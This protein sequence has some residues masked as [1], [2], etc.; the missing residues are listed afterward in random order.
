MSEPPREQRPRARPTE[1]I[2]LGTLP[3]GP[4]DTALNAD[5]PTR[6]APDAEEPP[7]GSDDALTLPAGAWLA[8]RRSGGLL[9]SSR[10]VVVY[11]D[12]R[13]AT[14]AIGGGQSARS[15]APRRLTEAQLAALRR[16]VEQIDF[17]RLPAPS[18]RQRPDAYAYEIVVRSGRTSHAVEVFDGSIPKPLAPLIRQ[19]NQLLSRDG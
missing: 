6:A 3:E 17:G 15:G 18:G 10:E 2:V 13:V 16:V 7:R 5:A 12:G 1:E 8:L 19:L 11:R 14:N 4:H 9:F